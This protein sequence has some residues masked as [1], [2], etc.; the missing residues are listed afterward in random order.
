MHPFVVHYFSPSLQQ[1]L[2]QPIPK[3]R[4]FSRQLHQAY[5]QLFIAAPGLIA[6]TRYRIVISRHARRSLKA[7]SSRTCP[8]AAFK[9]ASSTRFFGSPTAARPCLNIF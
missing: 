5:A 6:V 2:Q 4:F 3:P 7:Y 1:D 9:T 8:T